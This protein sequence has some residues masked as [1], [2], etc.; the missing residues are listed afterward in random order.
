MSV[1]LRVTTELPVMPLKDRAARAAYQAEYQRKNPERCAYR[2]AKSRCEN[3]DAAAYPSYGGRGIKFLFKDFAEFYEHLGPRPAPGFTLDRIDNN[4]PYAPGNVRWVLHKVNSR[5]KRD[6]IK[7]TYKGITDSL[8][9]WCEALD[10]NYVQTY[11]RLKRGWSVEKAL[12]TPAKSRSDSEDE[13]GEA[14]CCNP[15]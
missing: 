13:Q 10:L 8:I 11:D 9:A 5:N 2:D 7:I 1:P 6:T 14:S 4:G 15:C 3:P 12:S